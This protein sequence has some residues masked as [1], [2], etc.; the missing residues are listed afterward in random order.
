M[1]KGQVNSGSFKKGEHRNHATEIKPGQHFS[2][3]TEFKKGLV[4]W[5]KSKAWSEEAKRKM[6]KARK[7]R[8]CGKHN[9][10]WKGGITPIHRIIRAS[11]EYKLWR[12]AVFE[13]DNFTCIWCGQK[14]KILH[15]DHI[16]P[17]SLF[18]AL[19]FAIDNGRTLCVNCHKKT[20]T[21]GPK[22][23]RVKK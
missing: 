2:K 9:P 4:P 23:K 15:A 13:R 3:K 20:D 6:S 11:P 18:P 10:F 14:G 8:F 19:R 7:G 12:R 22:S 5:N 1:R 17:F 21:Y 16:K